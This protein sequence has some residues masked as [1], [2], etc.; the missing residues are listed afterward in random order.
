MAQT[1]QSREPLR[2]SV[3]L[4]RAL[5][6]A[7]VVTALLSSLN[8]GML[9]LWLLPIATG[10]AALVARRIPRWQAMWAILVGLAGSQLFGLFPPGLAL[11]TEGVLW[12]VL[13]SIV[14]SAA[15]NQPLDAAAAGSQKDMTTAGQAADQSAR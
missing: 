7:C 12:L 2:I 9:F 3:R 15:R 13:G 14:A 4:I 6:L 5:G 8:G 11:I 10:F 1:S